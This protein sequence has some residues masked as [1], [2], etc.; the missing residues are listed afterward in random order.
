MTLSACGPLR[1]IAVEGVIGVGKTTLAVR[2]AA[3]LQAGLLCEQPADNPFLE[4]FYEGDGAGYALPAQL[5][6]LFQRLRQLR[7]LAQPGLF[8][9]AVVSDYLFDKD[10]LFA[11]LNLSD[12][13][14]ALYRHVHS[15]LAPRV[16]P[17]HV[18]VWLRAPVPVLLE[19]IR[20]RGIGMEQ[21]IGAVYL[22]R[23]AD[24]Y[25]AHFAAY[26][27]APVVAIDTERFH[28]AASDGDFA[29]LLR[30]IAAAAD[31]QPGTFG[32]AG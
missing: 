12:E 19:R 13:E 31:R 3:H 22:E 10:A 9:A 18:V 30:R 24:A 28:P 29:E 23:L 16:P 1:H 17:P 20:C 21:R 8:T 27:A 32:M 11:R 4:R 7:V 14:Y 5:F 26:R 2:L 25:A 15:R 6:F